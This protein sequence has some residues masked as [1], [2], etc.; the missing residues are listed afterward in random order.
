MNS[1]TKG[2]LYN[3]FNESRPKHNKPPDCDAAVEIVSKKLTVVADSAL[4]NDVKLALRGYKTY[5]Q[6]NRK[7]NSNERDNV[8]M[9]EVLISKENY[10]PYDTSEPL[11][12]NPPK[13]RK[14]FIELSKQMQHIRTDQ[15]L[16]NLK[17]FISNENKENNNDC[18]L[19][20]TQILGFLIYRINYMTNKKVADL[21]KTIFEDNFKEGESFDDL[22]AIALMHDLTLTKSG[23]RKVKSYLEKKKVHFLNSN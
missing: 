7:A 8:D 22:D 18:K 10:T 20:L 4:K 23:T 13:K 15:I 12:P 11:V 3:I 6:R 17:D 5:V 1:L 16:Q 19:N 21:G 9:G 2:E 14:S